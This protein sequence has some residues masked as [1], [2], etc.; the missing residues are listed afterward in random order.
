MAYTC[1][2]TFD[3]VSTAHRNWRAK[4][5]PNRDSKKC[6]YIHGYTKTFTFV[7]G[8]DDLDEFNWVYDY[9]TTSNGKEERTMTKIKNFIQNELDHGVT[10]DSQDPMLPKLFEMHDLELI[11]LIVI[12]VENGQSGSVEGLCRY[13][14]NTFDPMLRKESNNR[15]WIESV[16][17]S[18]HHKNSSTYT[19]DKDVQKDEVTQK[20]TINDTDQEKKVVDFDLLGIPKPKDDSLK[21]FLELIRKY[22]ES[23]DYKKAQKMFNLERYENEM[24]KFIDSNMHRS[25]LDSLIK[26]LK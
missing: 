18:E 11:K 26:L 19:F 23:D 24:R 16:T 2:K 15:V 21:E 9:G 6:S 13:L 17:I 1:T 12:P 7:F 10:T 22:Q 3:C 25:T 4:N 20:V 5:N 14:Y 8:C